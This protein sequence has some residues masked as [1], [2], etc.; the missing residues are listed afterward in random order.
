M[1]CNTTTCVSWHEIC[2][3][4]GHSIVVFVYIPFLHHLHVKSLDSSG[5]LSHGSPHTVCFQFIICGFPNSL[6]A[7]LCYV[8][9]LLPEPPN[10]WLLKPIH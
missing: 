5:L 1:I 2:L 7:L 4:G 9:S 10:H 3:T 6:A 8:T